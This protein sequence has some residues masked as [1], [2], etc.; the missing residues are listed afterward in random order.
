MGRIVCFF[1]GH[2]W[3]RNFEVDIDYAVAEL[4]ECPRC[5]KLYEFRRGWTIP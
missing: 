2:K 4:N 5:G 3:G 1:L